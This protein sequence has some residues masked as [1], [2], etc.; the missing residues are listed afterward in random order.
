LLHV[1]GGFHTVK[2]AS[3]CQEKVDNGEITKENSDPRWELFPCRV[4][5]FTEN[6]ETVQ[7]T[8]QRLGLEDNKPNQM[9]F[10][11]IYVKI[12]KQNLKLY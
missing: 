5:F 11:Y 4:Y 12:I 3:F 2:A 9:V 10:S 7:D 6:P 1:T 8:V